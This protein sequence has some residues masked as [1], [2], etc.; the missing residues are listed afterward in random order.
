MIIQKQ[1][2]EWREQMKKTVLPFVALVMAIE[3]YGFGVSKVFPEER[4]LAR[5]GETVITQSDLDLVIKRYET[6]GKAN[7]SLDEKKALLNALINGV[8]ISSEA[9]REKLDQKPEVKAQLRMMRNDLLAKEYILARIDPLVVVKDQE[10]DEIMKKNPNLVPKE[11]RILKEIVVKTEKEADEIYQE[12]KKGAD[13]S[14]IAAERSIAE[15][16]SRGGLVGTVAPGQLPP[17]QEPIVALLKEG[18]FSKPMK[19]G[20]GFRI[21]YLVERKVNSPEQTKTIERK[22][23]AKVVQLEKRKRLE[24]LVEQKVEELKHKVKVETYSDRLR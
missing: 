22:V 9:E 15:S 14:R 3:L 17:S 21:L 16:K 5:V 24:K 23:R 10:I 19:S 20:E 4:I 18:E 12:L 2:Q 6:M 11:T 1:D 7:P 8:L 13:F